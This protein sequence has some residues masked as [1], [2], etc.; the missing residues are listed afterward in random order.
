MKKQKKR[1]IPRPPLRLSRNPGVSS[2]LLVNP[3]KQLA[4]AMKP[5]VEKAV[6]KE[7]GRTMPKKK[8]K[9][10]QSRNAMALK[11]ARV[12]HALAALPATPPRIQVVEAPAKAARPRSKRKSIATTSRGDTA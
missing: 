11:V 2:L 7:V 12:K 8:R 1:K 3:A 5:I 9:K 4:Q 6:R 10:Q